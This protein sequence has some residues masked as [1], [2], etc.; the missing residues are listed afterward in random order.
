M[1]KKMY[2][3][4]WSNRSLENIQEVIDGVLYVEKWRDID[5]FEGLYKVSN[6]GRVKRLAKKYIRVDGWNIDLPDFIMKLVC[7]HKNVDY[8]TVRLYNNEFKKSFYVHRLV[9]NKF[10][11]NLLNK[12]TVN[13][14]F[15][16]KKDNRWK[17]LE[18]ATLS[19]NILHAFKHNLRCNSGENH[20]SHKLKEID[21]PE[22]RKSKESVKKLA[23]L[24]NVSIY[25][26]Y[27]VK[28][29]KIWTHV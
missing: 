8:L 10:L 7:T 13:H 27:L 19:E 1:K 2:I 26:I 5:G 21:I 6:F 14:K 12:K 20:P 18:F 24:Y 11:K 29:N 23:S 15:G 28:K 22:I 3:E 25:T 17:M 16:N 9:A 4:H